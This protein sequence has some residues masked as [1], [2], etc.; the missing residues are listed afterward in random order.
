MS[1]LFAWLVSRS[2]DRRLILLCSAIS[3]L[4]PCILGGLRQT[5]IGGDSALY[6]QPLAWDARS[7]PSL[8]SYIED[9]P[10]VEV[11]YKILTYAIM[12]TLNHE[13]WC[14]FFYQLITVSGI[15]IGAYKHR[16]SISLPFTMLLWLLFSY[17]GSYNIIRQSMAAS[18]VFMNIDQLE[19]KKYIKFAVTVAIASLFHNS[20]AILFVLF[21]G[22]HYVAT[23]EI[24]TSRPWLQNTLVCFG[25]IA[26]L[27]LK[28]ILFSL[29]VNNIS[30]IFLSDKYSV[31]MNNY[32]FFDDSY[33]LSRS[34]YLLLIG[35]IVMVLFY[36]KKAA[37]ILAGE[38]NCMN[39]IEFYLYNVIFYFMYSMAVQLA[40]GRVLAYTNSI[41]VLL[42]AALPRFV[43]EKHLKF[44]I[45]MTILT[46][47]I[48]MWWFGTI[49]RGY[50]LTYPYKS[51]LDDT[52]DMLL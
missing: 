33:A 17:N 52:L 46:Y 50:N 3:I 34:L 16:K 38:S 35:E 14:Y 4:V 25:V 32:L 19:T 13:N 44:M 45:F 12:K 43:K 5:G 2:K 27:M 40:T 48:L 42:I 10:S 18:I 9:N 39:N 22:M 36:R 41:N 31:Y 47:Y 1:T 7:A 37:H 8:L 26:V 51:I 28:R 24:F 21:F 49:H 30:N 20:A 11:G 29:F 15:Y 23:S 6:G